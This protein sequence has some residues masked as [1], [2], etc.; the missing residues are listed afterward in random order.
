MS[1]G[2][3]GFEIDDFRE[4]SWSESR[5]VGRTSPLSWEVWE[6]L[7]GIRREEE[8]ADRSGRE[9]HERSGRERPALAREER[10]E[11]ILS[12]RVR[13][14]YADRN[15]D[16][17]LRDSEIHSLGEV[18]KFRVVAIRDLAE[19]AYN[20]DRDRAEND[21]K[22]LQSQGL[23]KQT[24]IV[25][26]EHNPTQVVTLTKEGHKV[27]S[28]GKVVPASQTTYHGLK[29]PKEAFHDADLYRLYHKVTDEIESRGGRV[30]RVQLDYEMKREL[31]CRLARAAKDESR[32]RETLRKEVAERYHLKVVSGRIP[33]P[34]LSIEYVNEND[35]EIRRR[36]L[37]LATEHYRPRQLSEKA[38]AGFQ[39]Y[40]RRGET[41]RLRRIRD[42][43][44]LSAAIFSL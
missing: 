42:D 43:R 4:S 14:K 7:Q 23:A 44:E 25:D 16:Y 5:D 33:I 11:A 17:S 22:N 40:A 41:D 37:E 34:D 12:Q 32:D 29:K 8:R 28:R 20:G 18:G 15:K 27:L 3:D 31:Y 10:I 35:C 19:F 1:R 30:L 36:D 24:M 38:R 13:T 6:K 39:L 9:R 26:P 2:Y 21:V